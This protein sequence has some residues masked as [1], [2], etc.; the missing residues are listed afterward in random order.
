MGKRDV[1][2]KKNG[3][4]GK[5]AKSACDW[6]GCQVGRRVFDG[7]RGGYSPFRLFVLNLIFRRL[8][9]EP[10]SIVGVRGSDPKGC[11]RCMRSFFVKCFAGVVS[12]MLMLP[13]AAFAADV[14][15]RDQLEKRLDEEFAALMGGAIRSR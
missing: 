14:R 10:A 5:V 13:L 9:W 15:E 6:Q 11:D 7:W 1:I 2:V 4:V 12:A 3:G 8:S